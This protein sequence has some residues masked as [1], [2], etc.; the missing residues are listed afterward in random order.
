LIIK[1]EFIRTPDEDKCTFCDYAA[2]C[3]GEAN[4]Q[5]HEKLEDSKLEA[6][7]RLAAHA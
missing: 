1:G 6:Y 2:A 7:R 3:G 5:A 4:Q